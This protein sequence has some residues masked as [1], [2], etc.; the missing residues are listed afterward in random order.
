MLSIDAATRDNGC[1]RFVEGSHKRGL[2]DHDELDSTS[3]RIGLRGDMDAYE[4]TMLETEPGDGVFFGPLVIHGSA[5][6]KSGRQ[7]R[8][9]TFAFDRAGN[10]RQE[11]PERLLRR[12]PERT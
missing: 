11:R 2:V 8:A 7:R 4:A 1:T 3:F 5:P 9:N 6:N 10:W 12:R